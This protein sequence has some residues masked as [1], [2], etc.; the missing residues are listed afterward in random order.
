MGDLITQGRPWFEFLPSDN[1]GIK[2]FD[3]L[4]KGA[5]LE[6]TW[7]SWYPLTQRGEP[8]RGLLI[9]WSMSTCGKHSC[10]S[11]ILLPSMPTE[12]TP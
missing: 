8:G 4:R 10:L 7:V 6:N 9:Y 1:N 5:G 3:S 2:D 11:G 12:L